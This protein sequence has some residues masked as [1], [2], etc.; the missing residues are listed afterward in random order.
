MKK[1]TRLISLVLCAALALSMA[2]AVAFIVTYTNHACIGDGCK[3]CEQ[4][5]FC[6]QILN[7]KVLDSEKLAAFVFAGCF[8][9]LTILG[10]RYHQSD[11]TLVSM[12]VKLSC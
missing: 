6:E 7:K 10:Y 8:F 11:E 5:Q 2:L 3:I 1:Q 4:L 9:I 12:K